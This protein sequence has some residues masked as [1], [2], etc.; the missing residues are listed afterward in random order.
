[1]VAELYDASLR[2]ARVAETLEVLMDKE[3]IR[4]IRAGEKEYSRGKV[5]GG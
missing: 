5:C 1:M 4:R 2:F 3:T